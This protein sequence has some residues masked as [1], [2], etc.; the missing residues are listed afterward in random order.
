MNME[1]EVQ[2]G[3][4]G[5]ATNVMVLGSLYN[6]CIGYLKKPQTILATTI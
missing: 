4:I 3:V 1:I 2:T 6:S 5:R